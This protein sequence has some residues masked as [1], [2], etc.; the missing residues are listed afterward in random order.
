MVSHISATWQQLVEQGGHAFAQGNPQAGNELFSQALN[1]AHEAGAGE[2]EIGEIFFAYGLSLE[3]S[4]DSTAG[5]Q[6]LN[7]ALKTFEQGRSV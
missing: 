4:G 3:R 2:P 5:I 1:A 7:Q 6:R